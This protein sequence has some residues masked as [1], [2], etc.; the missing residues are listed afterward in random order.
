[1]SCSGMIGLMLEPKCS[2]A[3]TNECPC[4]YASRG[5]AHKPNPHFTTKNGKLYQ[6]RPYCERCGSMLADVDEFFVCGKCGLKKNKTLYPQYPKQ[7]TPGEVT[8]KQ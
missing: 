1:M 5:C 8:S 3:Y 6:N 2:K 4:Q 7:V